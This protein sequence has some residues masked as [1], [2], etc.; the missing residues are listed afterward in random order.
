LRLFNLS[1]VK[2]LPNVLGFSSLRRTF[3][4]LRGDFEVSKNLGYSL[5][6]LL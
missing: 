2:A 1:E 6:F 5:Q 3:E 4:E